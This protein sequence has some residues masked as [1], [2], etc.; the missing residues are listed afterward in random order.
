MHVSYLCRMLET[1]D[2]QRFMCRAGIQVGTDA[3]MNKVRLAFAEFLRDIQKSAIASMEADQRLTVYAKDIAAALIVHPT[4]TKLY[5]FDD[6]VEES[7]DDCDDDAF[8]DDESEGGAGD[9]DES[10]SNDDSCSDV[11]SGEDLATGNEDVCDDRS[12][13]DGEFSDAEDTIKH[14]AQFTDEDALWD[15]SHVGFVR[16][17]SE[18][19]QLALSREVS[20]PYMVSRHVVLK[21]WIALTP[22]AITRPALSALHNAVEHVIYR[23][24]VDG[25]LGSQFLYTVMESIV[26]EQAAETDR[27]EAELVECRA[28]LDQERAAR[29]RGRGGLREGSIYRENIPLPTSHP[30]PSSPPLKKTSSMVNP[31][32]PSAKKQQLVH[33]TI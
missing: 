6:V 25:K 22:L 15:A 31:D 12:F 19:M 11:E 1:R 21:M 33:L 32:L 30:S 17:E 10:S 20:S 4:R 14:A 27:L 23:E 26:E 5:G 13:G 29:K 18:K 2:V 16:L 24:L 3:A 9:D 28:S 7:I 8:S